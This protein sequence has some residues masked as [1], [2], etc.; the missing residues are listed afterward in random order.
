MGGLREGVLEDFCGITTTGIGYTR[1]REG[2]HAVRWS[3]PEGGY[4]EG[5]VFI[6][7]DI[8]IG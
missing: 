8:G 7:S 4:C 2:N 6:A 5:A 3:T 1:W